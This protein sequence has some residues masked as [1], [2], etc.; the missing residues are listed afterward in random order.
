[1]LGGFG[2]Q[3]RPGF[4]TVCLLAISLIAQSAQAEEIA[5]YCDSA[6]Y[7]I[8]VYRE[9]PPESSEPTL[10][11]RIF[12]REKSLIFADLPAQSSRFTE[13]FVYTSQSVLTDD[14]SNSLWTLFVPE[15]EG[16]ACLLFRNGAA[17]ASGTVTQRQQD[18]VSD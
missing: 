15:E 17:F 12:W 16:Q 3:F 5:A 9:N 10:R 11:I 2:I 1:M 13:G 6:F 8:N 18:K 14:Y 7:A 4:C